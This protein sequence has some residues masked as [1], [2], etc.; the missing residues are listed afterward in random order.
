MGISGVM[1]YTGVVN[2]TFEIRGFGDGGMDNPVGKIRSTR[3]SYKKP[4]VKNYI[5]WKAHVAMAFVEAL[6]AQDVEKGK[7]AEQRLAQGLLPLD[8]GKSRMYMKIHIYWK[9]Y[10]HSDPE[11]VFGSIADSIFQNDKYLAGAFDFTHQDK[12]V[13]PYVEV[14]ICQLEPQSSILRG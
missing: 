11:N 9:G 8:T 10:H 6:T 5:K 7:E 4:I 12:G 14:T 2:I 1:R 3:F 13:P